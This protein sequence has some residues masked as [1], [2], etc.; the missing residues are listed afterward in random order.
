MF[1]VLVLALSVI[2][3]VS[4]VAIEVKYDCLQSVQ[5]RL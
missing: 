1:D 2:N 3:F 4:D 5:R